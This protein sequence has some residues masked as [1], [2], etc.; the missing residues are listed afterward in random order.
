M[1][2][3]EIEGQV[4]DTQRVRRDREGFNTIAQTQIS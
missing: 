3:T 1:E 4:K 2:S